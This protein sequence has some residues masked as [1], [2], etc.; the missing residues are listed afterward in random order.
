MWALE[1]SGYNGYT[2]EQ[3][4]A[5]TESDAAGRSNLRH[6]WPETHSQGSPHPACRDHEEVA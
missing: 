2:M 5:L 1:D 4:V 3:D 6:A